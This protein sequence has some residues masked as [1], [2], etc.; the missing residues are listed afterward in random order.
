[1]GPEAPLVQSTG[2]ARHLGRHAARPRPTGRADPHHHRHGRR[3]HRAVR[4]S[5]R[6]RPCS[7]SRSCTAAACSTTRRCCRPWSARCAATASTSPSAASG[8]EP[9]W[10]F[11]PVGTLHGGDLPSPPR[12]ASSAPS[13]AARLHPAGRS[14]VRRL[15]RPRPPVGAATSLGG[16]AARPARP[17][18]RP[19]RSPSARTSSAACSTSAWRPARWPSPSLAKL[20]GTTVTLASGWKGGFIIPLFFMGATLGQLVHHAVP[21]HERDRCSWP[22]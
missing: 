22:R 19:T 13:G 3:L 11:P 1:M 20:V 18:G 8:I 2:H 9:V 21:G 17:A 5:A 16:L 4:R 6:R 12:S 10:H 14:A 7:P 15:L